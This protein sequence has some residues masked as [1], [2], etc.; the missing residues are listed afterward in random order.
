MKKIIIFTSDSTRHKAFRIFISNQKKVDVLRTYSERKQKK[1]ENNN[2]GLLNHFKKRNAYEKVFFNKIIKKFKDRSNNK[3]CNKGYV[4]TKRCLKEVLDL[5]PDLIVVYG[6]SILKGKILNIFKKKILNVHLGLSP[7][8]RGS[9]TNVF[10][11]VNN[12]PEFAGVTFM[13]INKEI[14]A[15]EVIHQFRS[16]LDKDDNIHK[17]GNKM[18]I[19]MFSCY[20]KLIVGLDKIERKKQIKSKINHYYKRK[21]FDQNKLNILNKNFKKNFLKNYLIKKKFRDKKVKIIQQSWL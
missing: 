7:Y 1:N 4:S 12:E 18:I 10:P 16:E 15:G 11:F 14:D 13:Y 8:Y 6:S 19:R 5:N 3:F 21:D 9:G 17:I 20:S 2:P